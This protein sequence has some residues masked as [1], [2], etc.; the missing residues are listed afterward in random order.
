MFFFKLNV[1]TLYIYKNCLFSFLGLSQS[2]PVTSYIKMIDIWMLFTMT[3]PFLEVVL[4]T[5]HE[6]FKNKRTSKIV[7]ETRVDVLE[8]KSREEDEEPNDEEAKKSNI[9]N[10]ALSMV[11]GNLKLP[12]LSLL[13]TI[14][15]W[16]VGIIHAYSSGD[17]LDVNKAECLTIDLA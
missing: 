2:L 1:F 7:P 17:V 9:M 3:I 4:H 12:I 13:F 10:L 14:I 16:T 11:M 15:F 8:V 6:V 5:T